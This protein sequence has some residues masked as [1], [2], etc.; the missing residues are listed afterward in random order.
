LNASVGTYA[1]TGQAATLTNAEASNFDASL[2]NRLRTAI[3]AVRLSTARRP[4]SLRTH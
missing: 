2:P 4:T 3:R 1:L